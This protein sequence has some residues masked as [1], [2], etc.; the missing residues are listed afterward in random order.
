MTSKKECF[1]LNVLN[2]TK[3]TAQN[4]FKGKR[5]EGRQRKLTVHAV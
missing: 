2:D 3:C 1:I 4:I 5:G